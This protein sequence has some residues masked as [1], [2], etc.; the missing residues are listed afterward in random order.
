MVAYKSLNENLENIELDTTKAPKFFCSYRSIAI[1]ITAYFILNISFCFLE[2]SCY[3][4]KAFYTYISVDGCIS[5]AIEL[6]KKRARR[7]L[8]ILV[9]FS[10][11]YA[12]DN[13]CLCVLYVLNIVV[14]SMAKV[15]LFFFG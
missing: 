2:D 13:L 1:I 3:I 5:I 4:L 14:I 10:L 9:A 7:L 12:F 8:V 11:Q 15:L 6:L